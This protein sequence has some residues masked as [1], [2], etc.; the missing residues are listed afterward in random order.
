[1][2][3]GIRWTEEQLAQHLKKVPAPAVP[4]TRKP[5][6]KPSLNDGNLSAAELPP[7]RGALRD[8]GMNKTEAEYA[9][10]LE[11]RQRRGDVLWWKYEAIALRLA[12][13][14]FYHPD[15]VV[16]LSSGVL[17]IHEVKGFMREDAA[18]KL[19]VVASM[20]PFVLRLIRKEKG[21]V[22]NISVI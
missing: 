19:K 15:F 22:W 10:M 11:E 8:L 5:S 1:M 14:T 3:N 17:E 9:G 6:G 12:D 4:A 7:A 2:S 16:L 21:G 13:R 20:Y 18:V